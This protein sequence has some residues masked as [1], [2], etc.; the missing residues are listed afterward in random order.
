MHWFE[1]SS[2]ENYCGWTIKWHT[3]FG[4]SARIRSSRTS[5]QGE[6]R[7]LGRKSIWNHILNLACRISEPIHLKS[8]IQSLVILEVNQ[9]VQKFVK[10]VQVE[11]KIKLIINS[12]SFRC[13]VATRCQMPSNLHINYMSYITLHNSVKSHI[14]VQWLHC[15]L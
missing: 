3:L 1:I 11:N 15:S 5:G 4:S 7:G 6:R 14:G 2:E 12:I 10:W 8:S 13:H 9:S